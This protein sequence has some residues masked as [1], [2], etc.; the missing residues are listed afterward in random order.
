MP[1]WSSWTSCW[2]G[3]LLRKGASQIWP[4]HAISELAARYGAVHSFSKRTF[5]VQHSYC[6]KLLSMEKSTNITV[7]VDAALAKEA[8][9][10]AAR[11]G[12]SLSRLV[13]EQLESLVQKDQAYPAA[14][15]R[16]RPRH[17]TG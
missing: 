8:K 10:L 12:T 14:P 13:A 2:T 9:V 6:A 16:A 7:K 11:R 15:R 1:V 3:P 17:K 5:Y 4:F